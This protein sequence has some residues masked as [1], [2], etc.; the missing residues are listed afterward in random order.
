MKSFAS[1]HI[2][3]CNELWD[4]VARWK[5]SQPTTFHS[6]ESRSVLVALTLARSFALTHTLSSVRYFI[7]HFGLSSSGCCTDEIVKILVVVV[8]M[9]L[10]LTTL[11]SCGTIRMELTHT[12]IRSAYYTWHWRST[13]AANS[14]AV[15]SHCNRK[16][17]DG[18]GDSSNNNNNSTE[19]PNR[20]RKSA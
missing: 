8:I 5:I 18:G 6:F 16:K 11:S 14:C 15:A 1:T 13:P 9:M 7:L 17:S 2:C 20:G 19:Q 12:H 10:M 4:S 3:T